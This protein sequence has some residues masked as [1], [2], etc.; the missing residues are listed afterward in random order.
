MATPMARLNWTQYP[1]GTVPDNSAADGQFGG[2]VAGPGGERGRR[3]VRRAPKPRSDRRVP[4]GRIPD[5]IHLGFA[6]AGHAFDRV[7]HLAR[8][9]GRRTA[10]RRRSCRA[11]WRTRS[12][13]CPACAKPRSI[14][15]GIRRGTPAACRT[16]PARCSICGDEYLV[17]LRRNPGAFDNI[18]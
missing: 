10:R 3:R 4:H 6:H 15:S 12:K 9:L 7:L 14:S 2:R 16:R 17:A 8:Q 13:A 1:Q 11:R 5:D 18:S